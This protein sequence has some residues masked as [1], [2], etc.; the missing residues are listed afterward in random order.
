[1]RGF[2]EENFKRLSSL[3]SRIDAGHGDAKR[4][5]SSTVICNSNT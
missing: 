3:I 4:L 2:V 5:K 1:M